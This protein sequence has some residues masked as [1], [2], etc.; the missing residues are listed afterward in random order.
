MSQRISQPRQNNSSRMGTAT[1]LMAIRK[2]RKI[3]SLFEVGAVF[4]DGMPTMG[5]LKRIEWRQ[6][7]SDDVGADPDRDENGQPEQNAEERLRRMAAQGL[8]G[9]DQDGG[10]RDDEPD[11]RRDGHDLLQGQQ[12]Y[13]YGKRATQGTDG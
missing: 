7:G 6:A 13:E 12:R 8:A 4:A 5:L 3:G 1:T 9:E 10:Y 2:N 11:R